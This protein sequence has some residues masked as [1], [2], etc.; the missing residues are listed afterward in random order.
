MAALPGLI[1]GLPELADPNWF[2]VAG[3]GTEVFGIGVV[4]LLVCGW[5]R[6]RRCII[7][8]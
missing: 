1:A 3:T 7:S 8:C 2:Y 5:R 4:G 6:R